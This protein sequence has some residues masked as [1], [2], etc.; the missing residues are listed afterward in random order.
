MNKKLLGALIST[1]IAS[2]AFATAPSPAFTGF[3]IGVGP[4]YTLGKLKGSDTSINKNGAGINAFLGFGQVV[5]GGLY[6]GGEV[7]FGLDGSRYNSKKDTATFKSKSRFTYN[8]AARLGYAFCEFLPYV[9]VGYE[10]RS[11]VTISAPGELD[12]SL[13]RNGLLL[14]LGADY[15]V[16]KNVF[17]RGEYNY[18]FGGRKKIDNSTVKTPTQ[19]FLIGAG[20]RF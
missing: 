6:M 7:S 8:I 9:K 4:T 11:K 16:T 14:G 1:A 13:N 3:Y 10:G 15:A 12:V 2:S 17:I 20:Y 19:T 5:Q 18:N